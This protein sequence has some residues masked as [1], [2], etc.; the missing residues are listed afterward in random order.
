MSVC[1]AVLCVPLLHLHCV[2][3]S[4]PFIIFFYFSYFCAIS[5]LAPLCLEP[6]TVNFFFSNFVQPFQHAYN[7]NRFRIC[8]QLLCS[9]TRTLYIQKLLVYVCV[10]LCLHLYA[11]CMRI[12]SLTFFIVI[13]GERGWVLGSCGSAELALLFFHQIF[14][15]H[16]V[17]NLQKMFIHSHEQF[18]FG[19]NLSCVAVAIVTT[20]FGYSFVVVVAPGIL[21]A[22]R[23][24]S[25]CFYCICEL[26]HIRSLQKRHFIG[27][28]II[29][30]CCFC[31]C[32]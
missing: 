7:C 2:P 11:C 10:Y 31:Y 14:F 18:V 4:L 9:L 22:C 3:T 19:V 16:Q 26:S 15:I 20:V 1:C 23:V 32:F 5:M 13:E 24:R 25:S 29:F 21:F 27:I 12:Y 8:I 28:L 17:F 30:L 6:V